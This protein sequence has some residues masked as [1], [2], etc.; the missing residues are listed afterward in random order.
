MQ[1]TDF[2]LNGRPLWWMILPRGFAPVSKIHKIAPRERRMPGDPAAKFFFNSC[3]PLPR[4][5]LVHRNVAPSH[6]TKYR[7]AR[8][9]SGLEPLARY[10]RIRRLNEDALS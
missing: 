3:P 5:A 8:A 9:I 2:V 6:S 4:V 7:T 10:F 1:N